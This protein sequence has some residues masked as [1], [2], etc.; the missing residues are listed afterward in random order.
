MV[1]ACNKEATKMVTPTKHLLTI[2]KTKFLQ[3]SK[4][5]ATETKD[6]V[7]YLPT[8]QTGKATLIPKVTPTKKMT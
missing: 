8:E 4:N 3:A 2:Q 6:V 1:E 5:Q 7:D